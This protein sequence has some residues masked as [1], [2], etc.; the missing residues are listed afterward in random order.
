MENKTKKIVFCA[1]F[2]A[3]TCVATMVI[4]IPSPLSGYINLGDSVVL[5]SGWLLGPVYG[6]CAAAIG[7][8]L[9]DIFYGYIVYFPATFI[10]KG[11]MAALFYQLYVKIKNKKA[12]LLASAV[13]AEA[14]MALG[15]YLFE[16]FLYGFKAA[17]INIPA[18]L[19]QAAAGLITGLILIKI[20]KRS[21][22]KF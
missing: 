19:I 6:F 3:L 9:A 7:S 17:V 5:L 18:N 2:A 16:G 13:A 20:F 11:L 22:I 8:A 12:N 15:Y 14:I 1:L 21:N 4:K 10:I